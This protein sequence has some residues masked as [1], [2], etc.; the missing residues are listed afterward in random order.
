MNFSDSPV[1]FALI[2]LNVIFSLIGFASASFTDKTIMWPY[3]VK[4]KKQY[5]RMITSGFL[6]ADLMHLFFNMF[7]LF[8]FGSAIEYYLQAYGLGGKAAYLAMYFLSLIVSDIPSYIRHKD[9]YNYRSLGASGA[10]CAVLF[11]TLVFGPW[12]QIQLY[13]VIRISFMI[14]AVLFL[15]YCINMGRKNQDHVNHA[16]HLWGSIFGLVFTILLIVV[17]NPPLLELVIK[18]VSEPSLMG[19]SPIYLK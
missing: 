1:T 18:E 10:V 3:V 17:L 7:T 19:R 15:I 4:R 2:A 9:D 16:A 5:Y 14:Y 12:N 11:A 6:H 8:F 13:G